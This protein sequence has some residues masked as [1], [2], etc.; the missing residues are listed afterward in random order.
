MHL[1]LLAIRL[2]EAITFETSHNVIPD[3]YNDKAL[4]YIIL[5]KSN[6]IDLVYFFLTKDILQQMSSVLCNEFINLNNFIQKMSAYYGNSLQILH[7]I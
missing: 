4:H 1:T 3:F 6:S 7:C 5:L 2:Q